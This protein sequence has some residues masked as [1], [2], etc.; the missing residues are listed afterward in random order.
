MSKTFK[1]VPP[2]IDPKEL[3]PFVE[4]NTTLSKSDIIGRMAGSVDY[5]LLQLMK[6]LQFHSISKDEEGRLLLL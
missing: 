5:S 3:T 6:L 1:P 4:K 2:F